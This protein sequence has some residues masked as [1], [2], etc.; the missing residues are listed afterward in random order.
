MLK[1]YIFL[2]QRLCILAIFLMSNAR[3]TFLLINIL[4]KV[5]YNNSP[6][7]RFDIRASNQK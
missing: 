5:T 3:C 7:K 4:Y 6:K 2:S 1:V